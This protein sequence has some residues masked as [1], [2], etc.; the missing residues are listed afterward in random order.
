M[1]ILPHVPTAWNE[2]SAARQPDFE[3][4]RVFATRRRHRPPRRWLG[5]GLFRERRHTT[6]QGHSLFC[7]QGKRRHLAHRPDAAQLPDQEPQRGGACAQG[8]G[9]SG[10]AGKQ[11]P[12]CARIVGPLLGLCPQR[13]PERLRTCATWPLQAGRRHRQRTGVLLAVAGAVQVPRRCTQRTRTDPHP[14]RTGAANCAPR[15]LQFP[16]QQRPGFVDPRQH[17]PALPGAPA[18]VCRGAP[19][20]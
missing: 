18:P 6:R 1:I 10:L 3:L 9:G 16:A 8:H 14:G 4:H 11:P 7:R 15:H 2:Q 12:F 20:R 5:H 13:R 17:Q 19:A